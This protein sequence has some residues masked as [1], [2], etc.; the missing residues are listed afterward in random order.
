MFDFWKKRKE[1]R[2]MKQQQND[3]ENYLYTTYQYFVASPQFEWAQTGIAYYQGDNDILNRVIYRSV[4]G[5]KTVDKDAINNKLVHPFAKALVDQKIDYALAKP[6]KLECADEQYLEWFN[7]WAEE[8]SWE[9]WLRFLNLH[10]SNTGMGWLH[11]YINE[12]GEF[13]FVVLPFKEVI[14]IWTDSLQTD[15]EGCIRVYQ[16]ASGATFSGE[17]KTHLEY[18]TKEGMQHYVIDGDALINET[19]NYNWLSQVQGDYNGFV[20]H[21]AKNGQPKNWG[22]VPFIPFCN[23]VDSLPDISYCKSLIDAYDLDRSDLDNTLQA[24]RNFILVIDGAGGSEATDIQRN[25]KATGI[26]N[27]PN[28]NQAPVKAS[29]LSAPIDS[30]ASTEH[31][32]MLKQNIIELMQGV[33]LNLDLSIPPSGVSLQLLFS[34]LEIKCRGLEA[35]NRQAFRSL[36]YFIKKYLEENNI[37]KPTANIKMTFDFNTIANENEQADTFNKKM[38]AYKKAKGVVS[39]KTLMENHEW[40]K[41]AN[42]EL[43]NLEKQKD[44]YFNKGDLRKYGL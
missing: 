4:D 28:P 22:Q 44:D 9:Y 10:A 18:W 24:L 14:P 17:S 33:N 12:D 21:Y 27:L 1:K 41:D 2:K 11:P 6:P 29:I 37:M 38:D 16:T 42:E 23:N 36:Q 32:T 13:K 25:I 39:D 3:L 31:A 35:Q 30:N 7:N 43:Q 5:N 8:N 40:V 26:L 15:L 34:G 19:V 20:P